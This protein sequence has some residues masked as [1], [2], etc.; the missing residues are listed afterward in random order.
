LPRLFGV[1]TIL[2]WLAFAVQTGP[3]P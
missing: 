2:V 1:G 3:S